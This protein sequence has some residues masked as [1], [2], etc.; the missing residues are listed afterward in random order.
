[1]YSNKIFEILKNPLNAGG[2][3][4]SNG[5]GKYIDKECG[6]YVKIYLKINESEKIVDAH[7]KT[8]GAVGAI[9]ASSAICSVVIGKTIEQAR[10]V[11]VIDVLEVTGSYPSTKL[12]TVD[13]AIKALN[14]AIDNYF[15]DYEKNSKK[16]KAIKETKKSKLEIAEEQRETQNNAQEQVSNNEESES[17]SNISHEET[18]DLF[19]KYFSSENMATLNGKEVKHFENSKS[20]TPVVETKI[21]SDEDIKALEAKNKLKN[22]ETNSEKSVS[23]AKARFDAMFEE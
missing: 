22:A 21:L 13:F 10:E 8:M 5:I 18:V 1:M 11:K 14:L 4:G 7:F 23:S 16:A 19:E 2:L 17:Q 9:V 3:Q 15:D 6:D 20:F 12:Y